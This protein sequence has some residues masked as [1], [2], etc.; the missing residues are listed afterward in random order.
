MKIAIAGTGYAGL[1]NALLLAQHN[2]VV[3]LDIVPQRVAML[4]SPL[5]AWILCPGNPWHQTLNKPTTNVHAYP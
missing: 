4:S 5:T 3:A 2:D 1:S